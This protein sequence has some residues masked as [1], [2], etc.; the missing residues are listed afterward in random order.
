MARQVLN[1]KHLSS[2]F[3]ELAYDSLHEIFVN[4]SCGSYA[5]IPYDKKRR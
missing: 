3:T 2:D 5:S 4:L 1:S